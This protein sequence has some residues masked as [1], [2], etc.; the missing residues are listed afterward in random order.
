M[1]LNDL[2]SSLLT[3]AKAR[4]EHPE[5]L[6]FDN[7][8][9]GAHT[10]LQILS[11][12]AADPSQIS[13]KMDGSPSLI[14]GWRGDEFVLTDKAGFSAKSYDGLTTS[15]EDI[16]RML[17]GRKM[18]DTSPQAMAS[19][20]S[21][22]R[23]IA[24]LYP[25]LRQV[26]PKS[27]EGYVQ[28]DLLWTETPPLVDGSY[29]F[30]PVKIKYRVPANSSL[31][32]KIARSQV[33]MVFHSYYSSPEDPEPQSLRNAR[34]LGF[35]ETAGLVI[36]PHELRLE[37][38]LQ[39][40][41]G[42]KEQL[43]R[44]LR[45]HASDIGQFIGHA[46]LSER[47]LLALPGLMKSFVAWKAGEGSATFD[48]APEEFL[49]WLLSAASKSTDKMKEKVLLWVE[50][51]REGYNCCVAAGGSTSQAQDGS[52]ASNRQSS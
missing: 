43:D 7:G 9:A 3:E 27:F 15:A 25:I 33:G 34:A 1:L 50:S 16:E 22:A 21:Y 20:M 19:R 36:V 5:D 35:K 40:N 42:L 17:M 32:R 38:T 2:F 39:L 18:K 30:K 45:G 23:K 28:G 48:R 13:V 41:P 11:S 51:N 46:N 8:L 44:V 29:E 47:E 10:A 26:V 49:E 31:G 14:A 12:T 52:Q 6:V 4:I 37:P 24:D